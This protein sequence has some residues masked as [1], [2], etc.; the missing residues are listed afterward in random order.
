VKTQLI[1][2]ERYPLAERSKRRVAIKEGDC[3]Q[4][5]SMAPSL[6]DGTDGLQ[7]PLQ[8]R[9]PTS[10]LVRLTRGFQRRQGA[11][12]EIAA[13]AAAAAAST[14]GAI[15]PIIGHAI[16]DAGGLVLYMLQ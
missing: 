3:Y 5:I 1:P 9:T 8:L 4:N 15:S 16:V 10:N 2:A 14:N 11:C 6:N 12:Q 13:P 7:C